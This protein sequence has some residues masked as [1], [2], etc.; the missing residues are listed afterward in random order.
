MGE[1]E[2]ARPERGSA[3]GGGH[4]GR[5]RP[6]GEGPGALKD[7]RWRSDSRWSP[8]IVCRYF[9]AVILGFNRHTR[10]HTVAQ[11]L[12][13]TI[14]RCFEQDLGCK[15]ETCRSTQKSLSLVYWNRAAILFDLFA[16]ILS[17]QMAFAL[18]TGFITGFKK[19]ISALFLPLSAHPLLI[20]EFS[21]SS[22]AISLT[23]LNSPGVRRSKF[24]FP[25]LE[26]VVPPELFFFFRFSSP[27][28]T[29]S[30]PFVASFP[31]LYSRGR[32]NPHF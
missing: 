22:G 1:H 26:F 28:A 10:M 16:P 4:K 32:R 15:M 20:R 30:S 11:K 9:G 25:R 23:T 13:C 7:L 12:Y 17:A 19:I 27:F 18:N 14:D 8:V 6:L 21:S 24:A 3:V 5:N 29:R 2:C 31:R